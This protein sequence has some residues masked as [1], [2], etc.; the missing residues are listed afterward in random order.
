LPASRLHAVERHAQAGSSETGFLSHSLVLGTIAGTKVRLHWTFLV[1]LVWIGSAFLVGG[2]PGAALSGLTLVI[3]VFA[4]VVAHEFGH[5]AM[6]RRFGYSSPDVTLL[7]IGGIARFQAIPEQPGQ[8]LAVALAGPA[9]N[10]VIAGLLIG[11]FG[12]ELSSPNLTAGLSPKDILPA[13]AAINLVLAL[14]NLLP[15][16]PMDG[17]RAFRAI[18][19]LFLERSRATR[20]AAHVGQALAI[21]FGLFGILTG[22]VLLILIALF[23]YFA[24][25]AESQAAQLRRAAE[26]L[27]VEDAM[28]TELLPLS[29]S[30]TLEDAARL[31][32]RTDQREFPVFDEAGVL[33]G[34]LTREGLIGGLNVH[35]PGLPVAQAM[36][37]DFQTVQV[38]GALVEALPQM[39][40]SAHPIVV[41]DGGGAF[42]GLL[43]RENLGEL[44]LLANARSRG[45]SQSAP[46]VSGHSRSETHERW[47]HR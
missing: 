39:E 16:F 18:L 2:G 20:I 15:A 21:G 17:G 8:E 36:L 31:L 3:A 33:V 26:R 10:L 38:E 45:I 29:A 1:F 6:A 27:R 5:I 7:P 24:A 47:A 4:C 9:V 42:R 34:I 23:V 19:S 37:G 28:V 35:G 40:S 25:S 30:D 22:H 43:T 46:P 14:F 41:V 44:L 11:V 12:V 32:L 13:L